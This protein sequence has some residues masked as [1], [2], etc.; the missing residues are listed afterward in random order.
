MT[1]LFF[2]IVF[3]GEIHPDTL[4]QA[5]QH[6]SGANLGAEDGFSALAVSGAFLLFHSCFIIAALHGTRVAGKRGKPRALL[7]ARTLVCSGS[8]YTIKGL[9]MN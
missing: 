1:A 8:F 9:R 4:L 7:P 2:F 6:S 5:E 3:I